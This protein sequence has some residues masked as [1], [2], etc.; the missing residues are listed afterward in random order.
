MCAKLVTTHL[1]KWEPT[2]SQ[3]RTQD[4][5][6]SSSG[7]LEG[8]S[9]DWETGYRGVSPQNINFIYGL[10]DIF[11]NSQFLESGPFLTIEKMTFF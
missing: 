9:G 5:A 6:K 7:L 10:R 3:I 2:K 1:S 8:G 4:E 11:V